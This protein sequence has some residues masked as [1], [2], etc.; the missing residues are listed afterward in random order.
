MDNEKILQAVK[1]LTEYATLDNDDYRAPIVENLIKCAESDETV[2]GKIS[3]IV[4]TLAT[5]SDVA[6]IPAMKLDYVSCEFGEKLYHEIISGISAFGTDDN[7]AYELLRRGWV[8]SGTELFNR[9]SLRELERLN[10]YA[11]AGF[12]HRVAI[13][14]DYNY[15]TDT[16]EAAQFIESV[17]ND[18]NPDAAL[19]LF[20]NVLQFASLLNP[21][22]YFVDK[23]QMFP[24]KSWKES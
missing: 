24:E 12:L 6:V 9:S 3:R 11:G 20:G 4:A 7:R 15:K 22:I 10:P 23:Y 16:L 13:E 2:K 21:S 5:D 19:L 1:K 17:Y 8:A 14:I 18:I